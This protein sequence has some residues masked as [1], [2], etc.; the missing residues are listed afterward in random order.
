ML[1]LILGQILLSFDVFCILIWKVLRFGP[2]RLVVEMFKSRAIIRQHISKLLEEMLVSQ[3]RWRL[4]EEA[5]DPNSDRQN[6]QPEVEVPRGL[7]LTPRSFKP[8][9]SV[10]SSR[11]LQGHR[12]NSNLEVLTSHDS[13]GAEQPK[14][15]QRHKFQRCPKMAQTTK[16][17][18]R[19]SRLS[20]VGQSSCTAARLWLAEPIMKAQQCQAWGVVW[21]W[22]S[23]PTARIEWRTLQSFKIFTS[24]KLRNP[25]FP[26]LSL[27][28]A[29]PLL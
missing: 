13:N 27:T 15:W 16:S 28:D 11:N 24:F 23:A 17:N 10:S 1:S 3:S 19:H 5:S 25:K 22:A 29:W 6:K 12:Q 14:S 21:S 7:S 8:P 26:Q 2:L 9:G 20:Q 18:V 4:G